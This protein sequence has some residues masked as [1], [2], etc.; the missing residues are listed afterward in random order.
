MG[1]IIEDV[2]KKFKLTTVGTPAYAAP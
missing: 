2:N 1:K